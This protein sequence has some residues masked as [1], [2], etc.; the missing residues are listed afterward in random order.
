MHGIC[1]KSVTNDFFRVARDPDKRGPDKRGV[2]V[3]LF[4]RYTAPVIL[5]V[6]V[7]LVM[8]GAGGGGGGGGGAAGGG[9]GDTNSDLY[10]Q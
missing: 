5:V 9:T 2:T 4:M 6:L 8:V 1:C 3:R 7:L 10:Y